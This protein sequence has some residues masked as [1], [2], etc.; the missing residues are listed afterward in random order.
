MYITVTKLKLIYACRKIT[1]K[2]L[3][4]KIFEEVIYNI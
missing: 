2:N 1:T 4:P 3:A